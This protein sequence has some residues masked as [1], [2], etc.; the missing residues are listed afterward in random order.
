MNRKR[1]IFALGLVSLVLLDLLFF[2]WAPYPKS[3]FGTYLFFLSNIKTILSEAATRIIYFFVFYAV[4]VEIVFSSKS[5]NPSAKKEKSALLFLLLFSQLI[6][7]GVRLA[8]LWALGRYSWFTADV[9]TA[10]NWFAIAQITKKRLFGEKLGKPFLIVLSALLALF[11]LASIV[12]DIR[13]LREESI[14]AAKYVETSAFARSQ[15]LNDAIFHETRNMIQDALSGAA[16]LW[17]LNRSSADNESVQQQSKMREFCVFLLRISLIVSTVFFISILKSAFLP[18]SSLGVSSISAQHV[19][20]NR[21]QFLSFDRKY[22]SVYRNHGEGIDEEVYVGTLCKAWYGEK[23]LFSFSTAG[24]DD[25]YSGGVSYGK[26]SNKSWIIREKEGA[27]YNLLNDRFVVYIDKDNCITID[28]KNSKK[29]DE[30]ARV[31]WL[32]E[33]LLREGYWACPEYSF[34]YLAT[35]DYDFI[36]PYLE[37]YT[38]HDFYQEELEKN[39]EIKPAYIE[40]LAR[41]VQRCVTE[42]GSPSHDE[43]DN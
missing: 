41:N 5:L 15:R 3:L 38:D 8:V 10:V 21:E 6:I 11:L 20:S 2:V 26:E 32:L 35:W 42:D 24:K 12:L 22:L 34:N 29:N 14:L 19:Q 9:F 17:L 37:R 13:A 40:E 39:D 23:R 4:W 27:S 30:D 33:E 28:L 18:A 36:C 7:D 31:T 25:G 1:Q 43:N 16:V